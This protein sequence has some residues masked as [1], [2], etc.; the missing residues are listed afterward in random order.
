MRNSAIFRWVYL[1]AVCA[2]MACVSTGSVTEKSKAPADMVTLYAEKARTLEQSGD[3]VQAAH[4]YNLAHAV[5][6]KDPQITESLA[7]I[8]AER[9]QLADQYYRKGI[10][11]YAKGKY[12]DSRQSLLKALRLQPDH[13]DAL[14]KLK[15]R[16]RI[17]ANRFILHTVQPGESISMI[18]KKYYG[19]PTQYAVIAQYNN[20][21]D[22]TQIR[23]GQEL[24]VPE[25]ERLPFNIDKKTQQVKTEAPDSISLD[26]WP[27]EETDSQEESTKVASVQSQAA[28]YQA[29]GLN[30]LRAKKYDAAIIEFKKVLS[31]QPNNQEAK[32][33]LFRSHYEW[34]QDLMASKKYISAKQEFEKSLSLNKDCQQCHRYIEECETSYK[35]LHYQRGIQFFGAEKPDDAIAEWQKVREL[36]PDYKQ[37]NQYIKKAE[38]ISE[39]IK[40]LK[41]QSN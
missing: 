12:A 20:L 33:H 4:Y 32:D 14:K 3:I 13:A 9:R 30:F 25:V 7:R 27:E 6:P 41:Q 38:I 36:D 24:K 2:I 18:S 23:L 17:T 5:D 34:G 1:L 16:T 10:A 26:T 37:V 22:A 31:A 15:T 29:T 11:L 8:S 19:D 40:K 21:P 35:E 28:S 39:N